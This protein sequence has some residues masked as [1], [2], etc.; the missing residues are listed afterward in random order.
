VSVDVD[1]RDRA[2]QDCRSQPFGGSEFSGLTASS[3]HQA[4]R[5]VEAITRVAAGLAERIESIRSSFHESATPAPPEAQPM[6]ADGQCALTGR[7]HQESCGCGRVAVLSEDRW[8]GSDVISITSHA[9]RMWVFPYALDLMA[10]PARGRAGV[11]PPGRCGRRLDGAGGGGRGR[12]VS[13][14]GG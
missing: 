2:S 3:C 11:I 14:G 8:T 12:G 5:M 7:C 13:A 9:Q 4:S 1:S 6:D 10:C